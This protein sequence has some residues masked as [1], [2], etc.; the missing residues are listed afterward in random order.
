MSQLHDVF[1]VT[2]W[3]ESDGAWR[4]FDRGAFGATNIRR[5][6]E[7]PLIVQQSTGLAFALLTRVPTAQLDALRTPSATM[8]VYCGN[9]YTRTKV[10]DEWVI[11]EY[12]NP[13]SVT[14][15]TAMPAHDTP[16]TAQNVSDV[17][18]WIGAQ[19]GGAESTPSTFSDAVSWVGSEIAAGRSVD[20]ALFKPVLE[21]LM[22]GGAFVAPR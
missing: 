6:G 15:G 14:L 4:A 5:V 12:A 9:T 17:G 19:F 1:V 8:M 10:D 13:V 21:T 18:S 2:R 3:T 16:F 11:T 20:R 22:A 7:Q